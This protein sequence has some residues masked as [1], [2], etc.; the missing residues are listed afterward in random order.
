MSNWRMNRRKK[1][2]NNNDTLF[3]KREGVVNN[4]GYYPKNG[5]KIM[6]ISTRGIF[7]A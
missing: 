7:V 3:A 6:N 4:M 1:T 2:I 5:V